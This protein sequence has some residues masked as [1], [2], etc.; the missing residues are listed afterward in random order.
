[1]EPRHASGRTSLCSSKENLQ[2][3]MKG[4]GIRAFKCWSRSPTDG[5]ENEI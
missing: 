4:L 1:M 5:Y 2:W 3:I